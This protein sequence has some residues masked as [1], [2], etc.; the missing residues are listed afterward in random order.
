M[1][2]SIYGTILLLIL[3]VNCTAQESNTIQVAVKPEVVNERLPLVEDRPIKNVIFIIGDGTGLVQLTSGQ[4]KLVGAEGLL[5]LQ[6]MPVTGIVKTYSSNGLI[7]DSAAGATAYSCGVK[8]DNG[9]IAQLP[10]ERECKTILELAEEKGLSTG[11]V[12]TSGVTHATPA[13]YAAHVRAR[14][15]EEE[16]AVD[17]LEADMEVILGG[18]WEFF[19]PSGEEG[20]EREDN[21]NLINEFEEKGYEYVDSKMALESSESDKLL[22]LFSPGGMPSED[23]T[24]TLAEMS[25]KAIEVL[26]QNED[27]FFLMIE[28]SQIDWGGHGNDTEYVLREV[29]DFDAAIKRVLDF[30]VEDGETLVV[31]T[32]DHETGGMAINSHYDRRDE[33]EIAWTTTG[34]T[35]VPV[36]LM[37]Y[38]PHAIKFTGWQ[39]NTE[40]GIKVAELFGVG[41]LPQIIEE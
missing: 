30:A 9:K 3:S 15:M 14:G 1:K 40:V 38:G 24:P 23:R 27:G 20:S 21:R 25:S 34:H 16:I 4:Y 31:L 35:G 33:V 36:P 5:H 39:E 26:S 18:G 12:S 41:T 37:A 17:Y 19:I 8:T 13:S 2:R 28:G 7:T 11:I 10:D 22:G 32:A 6:T 29:K